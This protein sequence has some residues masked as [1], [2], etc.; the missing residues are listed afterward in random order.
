MPG[1]GQPAPTV[2]MTGIDH[3]RPGAR[4]QE[5]QFRDTRRGPYIAGKQIVAWAGGVGCRMG[6]GPRPIKLLQRPDGE[7]I[8]K[9]VERFRAAARAFV[10]GN[11][12]QVP[13][14]R[15]HR[16]GQ[17]Q[18]AGVQC[19]AAAFALP[20]GNRGAREAEIGDMGKVHHLLSGLQRLADARPRRCGR[21]HGRKRRK[22]VPPF[23]IRCQ[24]G[25]QAAQIVGRRPVH[26]P[27][28]PLSGPVAVPVAAPPS[29]ARQSQLNPL[30]AFTS[31]SAK[32]LIV[33]KSARNRDTTVENR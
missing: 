23:R 20:T 5:C 27:S 6:V 15:P 17:A 14:Q 21:F 9:L 30:S 33:A 7:Q 29:H 3:G 11:F 13:R 31:H 32:L 2:E 19:R 25:E 8:K 26:A 18:M 22:H 10:D 4:H 12:R 1:I 24:F 16:P 28:P